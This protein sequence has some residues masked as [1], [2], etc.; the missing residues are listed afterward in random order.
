M[1][2]RRSA[3][4]PE[5]SKSWR[6]SR[7]EQPADIPWRRV[8][9]QSSVTRTGVRALSQSLAKTY[10]PK[11]VHV[12]HV[13]IDGVVDQPRT[14]AW[15]P[16]EKPDDEFLDPATIA[17]TYW[18]VA[19]QDKRCWTFETNVCPASRMFDMLTI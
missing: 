2:S 6:H 11:G 4:V 14:R 8:A 5:H 10:G 15:F 9:T 7:S 13:V 16:K 19:S 17:D 18:S 12:F 3:R 1:P